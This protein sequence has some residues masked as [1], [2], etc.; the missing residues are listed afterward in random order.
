MNNNMVQD[1]EVEKKTLLCRGDR[2]DP[3][4]QRAKRLLFLQPYD[5]F[6]RAAFGQAC[7]HPQKVFRPMVFRLLLIHP[8]CGGNYGNN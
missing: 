2:K 6:P 1:Q 4:H 5:G 3:R 8:F 7:S